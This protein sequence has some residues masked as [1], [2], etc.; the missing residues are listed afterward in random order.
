MN[1][2]RYFESGEY[3]MELKEFHISIEDFTVYNI[4]EGKR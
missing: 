1:N 2:I 4:W 3:Y